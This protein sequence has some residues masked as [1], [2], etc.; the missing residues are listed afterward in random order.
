MFVISSS[1]PGAQAKADALIYNVRNRGRN[2]MLLKRNFD[3]EKN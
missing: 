3:K 1:L 2:R